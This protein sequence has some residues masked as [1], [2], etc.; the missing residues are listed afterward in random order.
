MLF[1]WKTRCFFSPDDGPDH[2]L[3]E[4]VA[5]GGLNCVSTETATALAW[6]GL[7][8]TPECTTFESAH[9]YDAT[10]IRLANDQYHDAAHGSKCPD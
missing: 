4:P 7:Y 9:P 1:R 2:F 5:G 8:D 3:G 6:G 10:Q